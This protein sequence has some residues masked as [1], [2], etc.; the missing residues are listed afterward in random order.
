MIESYAESPSKSPRLDLLKKLM[1]RA[2]DPS[3]GDDEASNAAD[4]FVRVAR[5]DGFTVEQVGEALV[6]SKRQHSPPTE[7]PVEAQTVMPYGQHSGKDFDEIARKHPA[8]LNW[9]AEEFDNPIL[10]KAARVVFDYYA[11]QGRGK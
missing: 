3:C 4:E 8:Y 2:L 1:V 11:N 9:V 7:P 6:G 10:A 5:T